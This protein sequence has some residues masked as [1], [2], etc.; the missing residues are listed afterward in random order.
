MQYDKEN[1]A[2]KRIDHITKQDEAKH[3]RTHKNW[4]KVKLIYCQ[5]GTCYNWGVTHWLANLV[6]GISTLSYL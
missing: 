3:D 6:D 1:M 2:M 4:M 5:N